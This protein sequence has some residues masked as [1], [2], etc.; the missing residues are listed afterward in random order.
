MNLDELPFRLL[1]ALDDGTT[2]PMSFSGPIGIQ[3]SKY[4]KLPKVDFECFDCEV[5]DID[6]N[7]LSIDY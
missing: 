6:L 2:A 3:L 5:L 4:G 1:K 7:I